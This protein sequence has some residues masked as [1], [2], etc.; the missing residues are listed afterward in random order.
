MKK[1]GCP[2]WDSNSAPPVCYLNEENERTRVRIPP[3]MN[4][5]KLDKMDKLEKSDK[6]GQHEENCVKN[7]QHRKIG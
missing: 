5:T 3:N 4:W 1:Y 2:H 7:G 6:I